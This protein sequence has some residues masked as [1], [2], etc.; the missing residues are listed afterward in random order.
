MINSYTLSLFFEKFIIEKGY[1]ITLEGLLNTVI[2]AV[3]GL[4]IG[5]VL[6]TFITT[7]KIIPT[8]KPI[9]KI[10]R[11]VCDLYITVLRGTPLLVQLLLCHFALFPALGIRISYVAEAVVVFGFNSSAY[12]A[13][14]VRSGINSIDKGQMEAGRALGFSFTQTMLKIILPQAIRNVLPTLGNEFIALIK[15]TSVANLIAVTDLTRSLTAVAESTYD[16]F[17]PY[18]VLALIYLILVMIVTLLIKWFERRF[19]S[20]AR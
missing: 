2:I 9:M 5:F 3:M 4:I 12:L 16:Y 19:S 11:A 14:A 8:N 17:V 7:L 18:L 20:Y 6:G 13:E 15:E 10:V 1:L